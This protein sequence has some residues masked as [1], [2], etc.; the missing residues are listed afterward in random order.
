MT[1]SLMLI[2]VRYFFRKVHFSIVYNWLLSFL[3]QQI[4]VFIEKVSNWVFKTFIIHCSNT[5]KMCQS[6]CSSICSFVNIPV[7]TQ[8]Y[9]LSCA[10][11]QEVLNE[12]DEKLKELKSEFGEVYEAVTTTLSEINEY[13]PSGRYPLPELWNTCEKRKASLDE[14]IHQILKQWKICKQKR[15]RYWTV[16]RKTLFVSSDVTDAMNLSV[17]NWYLCLII[18]NMDYF[19]VLWYLFWTGLF[20]RAHNL[21]VLFYWIVLCFYEETI[22]GSSKKWVL[23]HFEIFGFFCSLLRTWDC[24]WSDVAENVL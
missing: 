8:V 18:Q 3:F 24:W 17:R 21:L 15:R 23:L 6:G 5:M 11:D 7:F 14:G 19:L 1:R 4:K 9:D 10:I 22:K 2:S 16:L 20:M 13:N 12:D